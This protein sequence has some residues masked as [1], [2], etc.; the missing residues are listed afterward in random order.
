[1][2]TSSIPLSNLQLELLKL[3]S[4]NISESELLEIKRFL[5]KFFMKKAINEADIIWDEKGYSDTLMQ[6]W[7]EE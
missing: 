5:A 2:I 3:Y 1:M 4:S 6:D 7:L